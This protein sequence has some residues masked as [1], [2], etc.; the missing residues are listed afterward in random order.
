MKKYSLILKNGHCIDPLN[1]IDALMDIAIANGKIANV[2]PHIADEEAEKCI[3]ISGLY[4]S[5]RLIDAHTHCYHSSGLPKA[6]AGDY[7]I[8]PDYYSF[9]SGV[10][11]MVDTGS[12]GSYNFGHFKSTVIDRV[13]TRILTYLNIAD[14]GMTTLMVE[15]YPDENDIVSFISACNCYSKEIVGIKIAHYWNKDRKDVEY[16]Q[17]VQKEV[18][19]PIMVDFGVFKKERPYYKLVGEI[20]SPGD[21]STHCFR[22]PVP[23]VDENKKVYPFL[24]EAKERGIK[25]DLGHGAGS[26]VYRNAIPAMEQGFFRILFLLIYM[27][28]V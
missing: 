19:L 2:M 14:Y 27:D 5:H 20:L 12:A 23:V 26:F 3:D 7:S 16:A 21:I 13:K 28:Y 15:Q 9:R 1:N 24:W 25:F 8:Q 18:S 17:K 10:T 4:I 6:W 22:A 11:T